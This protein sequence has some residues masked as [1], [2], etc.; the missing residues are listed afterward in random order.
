MLDEASEL[1]GTKGIML[2]S[3]DFLIGLD[4]FGERIQPLMRSRPRIV[5]AS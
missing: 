3:D 4:Q 1:P 2:T 5:A